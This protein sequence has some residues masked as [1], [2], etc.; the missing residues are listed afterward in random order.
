[1]LLQTLAKYDRLTTS[2]ASR[3]IPILLATV[4]QAKS[5]FA[6]STNEQLLLNSVKSLT[7]V[8]NR[9]GL[10]AVYEDDLTRV[11]RIVLGIAGK[12]DW[13]NFVHLVT[14]LN[15]FGQHF[16]NSDLAWGVVEVVFEK[17]WED[18]KRKR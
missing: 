8:L 18:G 10:P 9:P 15:A 11:V 5:N 4:N 3:L 7:A 16:P 2:Y 14:F 6:L 13:A 12:C 17:R 1:L